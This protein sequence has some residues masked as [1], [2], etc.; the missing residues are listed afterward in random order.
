MVLAQ[1]FILLVLSSP[2][3]FAQVSE[4]S[5]EPEELFDFWVGEWNVSWDEGD[6]SKGRGINIVE[7][8]LDGTV[9][10]ENF[11]I[12][13]GQQ[14]GFKGTSISVYQQRF[15]RWKQAWA[16][17]NGGYYDFTGDLDGEK[18]I[19]RTEMRELPDGRRLMQR[20]VFYDIAEDSLMWDWEAS[21]D[22]GETWT[23]NWRIRYNRI[24]ET[25]GN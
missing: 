4:E 24:T 23:L 3:L 20:M 17:N 13:E 10:Q 7:K 18:R 22:G 15:E 9:I 25:D 5:P 8:T 16:D 6:G 19:F 14:S 12:T 11:S 2:V 21:Y 1:C